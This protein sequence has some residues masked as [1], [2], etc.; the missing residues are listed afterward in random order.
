MLV[1]DMIIYDFLG[2]ISVILVSHTNQW[3]SVF[4]IWKPMAPY[5]PS[6]EASS[7]SGYGRSSRL[8]PLARSRSRSLERKSGFPSVQLMTGPSSNQKW[9][10][11]TRRGRSVSRGLRR[12]GSHSRTRIWTRSISVSRSR[13]PS[14]R[15]ARP[16]QRRRGRSHSRSRSRTHSSSRSGRSSLE[17]LLSRSRQPGRPDYI[18]NRRR[19]LSPPALPP[20]VVKESCATTVTKYHVTRPEVS[21]HDH[22]HHHHRHCHCHCHHHH[23]HHNHHHHHHH[24]HKPEAQVTYIRVSVRDVYPETLDYFGYPWEWSSVSLGFQGQIDSRLTSSLGSKVH[25]NKTKLHAG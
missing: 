14:L 18:Q 5:S 17:G 19:S 20:K 22:H 23:C 2:G 6:R 7:I 16:P 1:H 8:R 24:H 12:S 15:P 21:P 10:V 3:S 13:S 25:H 11:R 4:C 9:L